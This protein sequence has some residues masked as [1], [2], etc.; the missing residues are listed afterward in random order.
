MKI[1][2]GRSRLTHISCFTK[3][4][5]GRCGMNLRVK[6][7]LMLSA[8][9][10]LI[11]F[12]AAGTLLIF[13]K[14]SNTMSELLPVS[15]RNKLYNEFDRKIGEFAEAVKNWGL[16]GNPR[17]QGLY[18]NS[19]VDLNKSFENLSKTVNNKEKVEEI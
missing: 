1:F 9:L 4:R 3:R 14:M 15:E 11:A 10:I 16:T 5:Y 18:R 17:F 12:F 19:L 2:P 13:D 6:L 8:F 7:P